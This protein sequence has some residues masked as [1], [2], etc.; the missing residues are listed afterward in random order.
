MKMPDKSLIEV[1]ENPATA[2][3]N[4]LEVYDVPWKNND[5]YVPSDLD[6]IMNHSATK[7]ISRMTDM[8]LNTSGVL[9]DNALGILANVIYKIY[10]RK[11]DRL[12]ATYDFEYDPIK[13]Y[14]MT[15]T[16][17]DDI[18][19]H[20]FGHTNTRTDNLTHKKTGD[21]T[22]THDTT[23]ERTDELNTT[24]T[25]DIQGFNSNDYVPNSKDIIDNTGT[26]TVTQTG[27]DTTD[28]DITEKNTGTQGTVEGG[29]NTDTRNYT[30]TR[31][32]NIGV[33]TAQQ[34]IEDERKLWEFNFVNIVYN[35]IDSILVTNYYKGDD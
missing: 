17:T 19:E 25:T 32:G 4:A 29:T 30:L 27:T 33:T 11:W 35:D 23:N 13:N 26:Q 34:M 5:Y 28:Y 24:Q 2:I 20:E 12:Y 14:D 18:T 9:T 22:I 3:I 6:Y 10:K 16:M 15:E 1:I 31:S 21:E 8:L 7:Y